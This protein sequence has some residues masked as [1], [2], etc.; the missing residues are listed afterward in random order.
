[1]IYIMV[2][3]P[4]MASLRG[5]D[6]NRRRQ[7]GGWRLRRGAPQTPSVDPNQKQALAT[8]I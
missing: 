3:Y 8:R 2:P 1:L 5:R 6:R 7:R 4:P